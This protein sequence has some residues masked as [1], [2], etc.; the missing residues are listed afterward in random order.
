MTHWKLALIMGVVFVQG[1]SLLED[2]PEVRTKSALM[3]TTPATDVLSLESLDAWSAHWS[4]PTL[5]IDT[6]HFSEGAGSLA[7]GGGGFGRVISR[8]LSKSELDLG[9]DGATI[10]YELRYPD[11]PS[12]PFWTGA[13]QAYIDA[14]SVGIFHEYI[15]D[16]DLATLTPGQFETV[17]F[18]LPQQMIDKLKGDYDD[19][20]I[21]LSVNVP[22]GSAPVLLDEL[23]LEFDCGDGTTIV[24]AAL[25][26]RG[27]DC[28]NQ[29]DEDG[30]GTFTCQNGGLI[31]ASLRCD[32]IPQCTQGA[33]EKSCPGDF[34]CSDQSTVGA[35]HVCNGVSEC[36][37]G[38][39]EADCPTFTCQDGNQ[40]LARFHCDGSP[41]CL[42]GSDE[43]NCTTYTCGDRTLAVSTRC[44]GVRHCADGSDEAQCPGFL[45][46]HDGTM[47]VPRSQRCDGT[48]QC[49]DGSDEKGCFEFRSCDD[50][51]MGIPPVKWCD[52][53][54]DCLD[55]S[56]EFER[57]CP[58]DIY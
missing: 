1:C 20:R 14:P 38:A 8:A 34:T 13:T 51:A 50:G 36:S 39:D 43:A 11:P 17:R 44:D 7:I 56:D 6:V 58:R 48:V 41:Q 16:V 53:F 27:V 30:C 23:A 40:V 35:S 4:T 5:A 46:C 55:G 57:E 54:P 52:G 22:Q 31:H 24:R 12:D 19:L 32:G 25:C 29:S 3:T 49:N 42:D 15:T 26:D 18:S 2:D 47:G 10:S 9:Y 28:E 21:S 33:D 45:I 37:D